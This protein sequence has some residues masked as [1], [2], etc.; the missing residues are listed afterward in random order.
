M[1]KRAPCKASP[2]A[3]ETR[4]I[5]LATTTAIGTLKIP[6]GRTATATPQQLGAIGASIGYARRLTD[7]QDVAAQGY[8]GLITHRP[9]FTSTVKAPHREM[10]TDSLYRSRWWH[11]GGS[12]FGR[13]GPTPQLRGARSW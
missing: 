10:I 1:G 13:A 6:L 7:Q 3:A 5:A 2:I 4:D 9:E 12:K 8:A 11:T